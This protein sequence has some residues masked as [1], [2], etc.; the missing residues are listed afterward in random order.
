MF[1]PSSYVQPYGTFVFNG[2]P[3]KDGKSHKDTMKPD[4]RR[5]FLIRKNY[6]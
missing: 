2:K 1:L 3:S 4:F 6:D 5:R